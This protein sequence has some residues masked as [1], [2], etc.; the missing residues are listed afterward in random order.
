MSSPDQGK[1]F[2]DHGTGSSH[3]SGE[4]EPAG[5][6]R[7]DR[8]EEL[9]SASA[10]SA[11]DGS[12]LDDPEV[13]AGVGDRFVY[14][15][16]MAWDRVMIEIELMDDY[17]RRYP[18]HPWRLRTA[19]LR[20]IREAGLPDPPYDT[21]LPVR[22]SVEACERSGFDFALN[23]PLKPTETDM[24]IKDYFSFE[25][26]RNRQHAALFEEMIQRAFGQDRD[27][28]IG[29][30]LSFRAHGDFKW[31]NQIPS[32]DTL[33]FD[34]DLMQRVF[35]NFACAVMMKCASVPSEQRDE[36]LRD[37][38]EKMK[39]HAENPKAVESYDWPPLPHFVESISE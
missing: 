17:V 1:L 12:F 21:L 13:R 18:E 5:V 35:G 20:L 9:R 2:G 23:S 28:V 22:R 4:P 19:A 11:S 29:H 6:S 25:N 10:D 24:N 26:E 7:S 39:A 36:V 33:M 34:H 16:S 32:A 14:C 3:A 27:V 38:L 37:L 15:M 8:D 31:V 30:H